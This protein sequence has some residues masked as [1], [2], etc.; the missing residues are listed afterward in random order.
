M[1]DYRKYFKTDLAAGVVVF[2][3]ALPLCL[4]ISLASDAPLFSGIIAGVVGGI[5]VGM[6]SNSQINV[7]G[8]AAGLVVVTAVAIQTLGGFEP[9]LT[10]VVIA[11][12]LQ[13]ILGFLR[14]GTIAYFFPNSVIKGFLASIGLILI[15]KQLPHAFGVYSIIEKDDLSMSLIVEA[16]E[17]IAWGPTAIT[18]SS[19]LLIIIW[20]R[21]LRQKGGVFKVIP[22]TLMAVIL[23][24]AISETLSAWVPGLAPTP[25]QLV[26][27]PVANN[28]SEFSSY[29]TKPDFSVLSSGQVYGVALS[30]AL[31]ASLES[32]LSSEAGDKLDPFKRRTSTNRE[33]KA[34]GLGNLLSGF[35]GG[36]PVTVVIVRTTANVQAGGRTKTSVI[37]HGAIMLVSVALIPSF[38]NRIPLA[39][40]AAVLFVVGYKLTSYAVYKRVFLQGQKQFIPFAVTVIAVL[41]TDLL[42][43]IFAG[44][45]VSLLFLLHDNYRNAFRAGKITHAGAERTVMRL[46]EEV[47]FLNKAGIRRF[48]DDLPNNHTLV[49]DASTARMIHPDVIEIIY[50]FRENAQFRG[51]TLELEGF[52]DTPLDPEKSLIQ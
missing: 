52:A 49:I 47:T 50:D 7:S 39:A 51:I 31:I 42:T 12:V 38:L 37:A 30:M 23:G 9:M 18:I 14:A 35:I 45:I 15:L 33:L 34:Q 6:A 19:L 41:L 10:A 4:A 8:P 32:L 2:F 21:W 1:N 36:L 20:E 11:G 29:F 24:T 3:V 40:L 26:Q 46:A 27:L 48:L 25:S 28:I 22:S 44:S 13:V 17:Q 16:A 5:V 43:G